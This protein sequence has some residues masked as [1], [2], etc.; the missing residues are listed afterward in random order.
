ML[1][2]QKGRWL[3]LGFVVLTLTVPTVAMAADS[4]TE[5]ATAPTNRPAA[6]SQLTEIVATASRMA[7]DIQSEPN[8]TYRLEGQDATLHEGTR[9]TPQMLD[10]VPSV[11]VQKTSY[12]QSSPYL[13]GFTG[14]RTLCM[15]DGIRLNNSAFR[16]GP[17]QYWNTVD[18]LSIGHSELVM[19]PG[20]VLYGSDAI[21][22][23]LN[24][25]SPDPPDWD[26]ESVGQRHLYYRGATA[27]GS[28]VGR[29]QLGGRLSEQLGFV[30][31]Y[32]LKSFGDLRGGHDVGVQE[33]TGYDEQ[34]FDAKVNY[35][36]GENSLLTLGHQ[37]VRQDEAWR[38]HRTIYGIDW[39]GL[40]HGTDKVN[41]YDQ[42]RDLTY[43]R[44][45][46]T[47]LE[48][49]ADAVELTL[50]R[51]AQ[52]EDLYRV[53]KDDRIERQGFDVET[54][55]TT[56]QLQSHTAWGHWV[57]GLDYYHDLVDSYG[58]RY[59]ADGSLETVEI[60]GPVADDAS[61]DLAG[62]FAQDT[63]TCLD[64]RLDV[65][66][67]L[68]YTLAA[69]EADRVKDPIS[70]SQT[71]FKRDWQDASGS[72]RLLLP[73]VPDRRHVSYADVSQGFRAP[74]LSDLS[75]FD[76]A[77]SGE[78]EIPSTDLDPER[79]VTCEIGFKS[80]TDQLVSQISY[81]YTTVDGMIV[82]TPT[83]RLTSDDLVEV[84]KRNAGDGY[85]QGVE[86]SETYRFAPQWSTWL[87]ATWQDGRVDTYPSA[88]AAEPRR[89]YISRLMPPTAE[90]GLRWQSDE[91]AKYWCELVGK[92][93]TKADK[94]SAED[95][96]DA[97][98]IPPGGTPGYAVCHVR[99]G[100]QLTRALALALS[101]ENVLD[102]DYR[103]HGSGVNEPGRNVILTA[104]C[105]F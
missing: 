50:S 47:D 30:G 23:T 8:A 58:R 35:Y 85:V 64:D 59:M 90:L 78:L 38:T 92:A 67:G 7:R 4:P 44:F 84:T 34:D 33:H 5:A 69:A 16:S 93:A 57:Y 49:F 66:P 100:T 36:I 80:R 14:Y 53:A 19:G 77:R 89:D 88:T 1:L 61:Y 60:Q 51:H 102:E 74:S 98:R 48:G 73:L 10:G 13:R 83:G 20:S 42:A 63:I 9:A 45:K 41:A 3:A 79:Y 99:A 27:E 22:G 24:A 55:G 11:M 105:N 26:G 6:A 91:R 103:I 70:G 54:W 15:I 18:L 25:L 12:G 82:R 104:A 86:W 32:S 31:G 46:A 62:I 72:L 94:L 37:T 56:L 95:E 75:R 68:R 65:I 87:A 97:Q 101:V 81:Y 2:R 29:V 40:S 39:E 71:S 21:G 43:A 52:G 28:S 76:I 17:N 96:L